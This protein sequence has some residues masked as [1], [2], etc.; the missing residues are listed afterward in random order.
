MS[1]GY[2]VHVLMKTI[3]MTVIMPRCMN[4]RQNSNKRFFVCATYMDWC[5]W[6][7]SVIKQWKQNPMTIKI[8][9]EI[10]GQWLFDE[11]NCK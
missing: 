3:S 11:L 7:V 4:H 5:E 2:I 1:G 6:Y 8:T 9:T 10:D